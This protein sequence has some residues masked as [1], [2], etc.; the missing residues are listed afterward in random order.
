MKKD[1]KKIIMEWQSL[2]SGKKFITD[3]GVSM[4]EKLASGKTALIGRFAVWAPVEKYK[5]HQV[6]EV[7]TNCSYLQEKY[8]IEAEMIF[9]L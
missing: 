3:T 1:D 5:K 7:G 8:A 9:K 4:Q 2:V 6:I